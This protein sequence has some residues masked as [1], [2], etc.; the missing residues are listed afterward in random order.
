MVTSSP[1]FVAGCPRSGT[2]ALSWAIA[3]CPGYWTSV[4]TH[5]FYYLLRENWLETTYTKSNGPGSWID[6][7]AVSRGD[8]LRSIGEGIDRMM[9]Q[10]TEGLQWVDG[11]P[12]NI[13]VGGT[14]LEMFRGAHFFHAVRDPQS[15]CL[16]MLTSGFAEPWATDIDE[17][18]RTWN[19]YVG[20]GLQ[21]EK[22]YPDRVTRVRQEDMWTT[23]GEVA[24]HIGTRLG[25][26]DVEP[27]AAFLAHTRINSSEDKRTYAGSSPF[28][29][30]APVRNERCEFA[31]IHGEKIR[32]KTSKFR[33][34]CGYV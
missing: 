18:I 28:R 13:M 4:E 12:E 23:P 2:S 33:V 16:S 6:A 1:V 32:V 31:A 8:F 10:R 24:R 25:V 27:I 20:V 26:A 19:H 22:V 29:H 7:H 11:S 14:L 17:A 34:L 30:T 15:V 21:L 5:F 3:A 9:R